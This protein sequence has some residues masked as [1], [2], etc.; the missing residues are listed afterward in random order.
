MVG[1][2]RLVLGQDL[3]REA[4]NNSDGEQIEIPDDACPHCGERGYSCIDLGIGGNGN[5]EWDEHCTNS[6]CTIYHGTQT[7]SQF[8]HNDY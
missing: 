3:K 7:L 8:M 5:N 2:Q 6:N 4:M 1:T